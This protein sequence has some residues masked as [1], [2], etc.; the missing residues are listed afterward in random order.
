MEE[1][2]EEADGE[3]GRRKGMR[4]IGRRRVVEG[5]DGKEIV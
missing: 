4:D 2:K 1:G 5:G 3:R